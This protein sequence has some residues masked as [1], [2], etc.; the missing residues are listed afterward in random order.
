MPR[1]RAKLAGSE[2][3]VPVEHERHSRGRMGTGKV[4]KLALC[5]LEYD[6][7]WSRPPYDGG[8]RLP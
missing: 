4:E 2:G 5:P 3:S 8:P 7:S 6:T 1:K